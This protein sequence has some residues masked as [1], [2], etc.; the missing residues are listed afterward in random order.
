[1][2]LTA[3]AR[4]IPGTLAQEVVIDGRHR[5]ITDEPRRLGGEGRGPAPHE[6]FPAALAACIA[7]TL[8]MYARTKQWD[9]GDVLVDVDYDNEST[10]RRFEIAIELGGDLSAEQL[11]MLDKVAA[12]CPVRRA[13]ES[14]IEFSESVSCRRPTAP[15]ELDTVADD[16]Q[17]S[18]D[19]A[20]RALDESQKTFLP[21]ELH[22]R[23]R[24]L[25]HERAETAHELG[26]LAADVGV[27]AVPWISASP[28]GPS[29]LG[30]APGT[31]A[32]IFDLD[33]V[34]TDSGL[35]QAAAWAD[36]F[37]DL[38]LRS[39]EG[40]GW[41]F[42]PFDRDGEYGAFLDGRPRLEG[43]RLFLRSR[44]LRLPEGSPED[45]AAVDSIYGLA[46]RKS[47]VLGHALRV[48]G[49]NALPGARR[50]LEAAGRA[51]IG[52]AV[53]SSSTRTKPMLEQAG[54]AALVEARVDADQIAS[55]ALRSRPHPDL[56]LRAC[57]LLG[58]APL[59]AV[60]FVHNPDGVAAA[61]AAGLQVV[62]VSADPATR[63]RLHAFGADAVADGLEALLDRRL[64]SLAA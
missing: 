13:V 3:S 15:I 5:L 21:A 20:A 53:V 12:A 27:R 4:S 29:M 63:D 40:T 16:W 28:V 18:F 34:L 48:R 49:L 61:R 51:G 23:R 42:I 8:T 32:C 58:V 30:L 36:V 11:R 55:G 19:G 62:G 7:T 50:Y 26:A 39:T 35:V 6:L 59:E 38:L 2:G 31:R 45:G 46:R 52:R 9:I 24:R 47:D 57:E 37:D 41:R 64:A 17:R 1:M 14:G 44:G 33:G 43:I 25:A 54:L 22:A 10:P 60:A 56:V